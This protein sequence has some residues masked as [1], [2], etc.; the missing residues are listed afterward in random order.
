MTSAAPAS[1]VR[2]D[3]PGP[4]TW[5][6]DAVHFPRPVTRY[7]SELHPQPFGRGVREFTR[8]YGMLLDALDYR[9]VNGFAY[10]AMVPVAEADVPARLARAEEVFAGKLWR[11]QLRD[12]DEQ[13]KPA[14]IATHRELQAVDPSALSD[15]ELVAY[16]TRCREHHGEMIYQHM[17]HTG[18]AVVAIG[19]FLAHVGD[20]TGLPPADLLDLMRGAAPVSAGASAELDKLRSALAGDPAA[21]ELFASQDEPGRV[22]GSLRALGGEAGA[23]AAAY[24]DLV[25]YRLVNGFDISQPYALELPDVLLRAIRAAVT[26]IELDSGNLEARIAGVRGR[27]PEEHRAGFDELLEEARLMYRIRDE[28]GVFSDI[29][30][31]GIV[32]RAVLAAGRRLADAGRIHAA[33]HLVDAGFDEMCA[34]VSGDDGPSADELAA[35]FAE[36]T[37]RTAKD[38]PPLL[39]PPS[40]PPPD[41]SG[42]P[43]GAARM[44]RATM[45]A[46]GQMFGSSEAAHDEHLLRGLA[47]SRGVYEG[48]ARRVSDPS[49]FARIAQGDVLVTEST[50]EAFNILLPLLGA[51]VTDS[52]GLLSHAAIVAREYGIPGVVG[53]RQATELIPD[54]ARVRV[55]GGAGE[56]TVLG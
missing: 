25:G 45:I 13:F 37:S 3:P 7:W 55:D 14:S 51:I 41:M 43:P 40:P 49:E 9:Y 26:G 53:T 18:A 2:F 47:A 48:P 28:R 16:L 27:V 4:G 54:G 5:E 1:E 56:V 31:A 12:W 42:L 20:W 6:L 36:R 24:L 10:K 44:M 21:R 50:S 35:R 52:G 30:A 15:E 46:I 17:R 39:G 19:D 34:L 29:W 38:A 8:Y 11:D 32:R 23:A 22:L 33:E